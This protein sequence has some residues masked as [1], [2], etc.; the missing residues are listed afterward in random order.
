MLSYP[1]AQLSKRLD[2]AMFTAAAG[3]GH[4]G[5]WSSA[6]GKSEAA[7]ELLFPDAR[8]PISASGHGSPR[9]AF[10]AGSHVR[11]EQDHP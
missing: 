11:R 7:N 2:V 9:I 8:M 6:I 4:S 10:R 3:K 1:N 5:H